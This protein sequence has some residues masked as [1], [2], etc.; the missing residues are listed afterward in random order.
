MSLLD[1]DPRE[2]FMRDLFTMK[3]D[4]RT[5]AP[6]FIPGEEVEVQWRFVCFFVFFLSWLELFYYFY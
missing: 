6:F 1:W 4:S 2:V 3:L 5:G